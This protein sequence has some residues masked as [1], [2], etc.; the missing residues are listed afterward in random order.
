MFKDWQLAML[1]D[2]GLTDTDVGLVNRV[3]LELK[4]LE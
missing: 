3:C 4:W 1:E 2:L